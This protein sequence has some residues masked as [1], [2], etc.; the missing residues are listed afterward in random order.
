MDIE[1]SF[2]RWLR[3]RRRALDL[4][5][6]DL[7]RWVGCSV[8]TIRKI[9][10]DERRPSRQIA[11]R[12]ANCLKIPAEERAAII[13]LARGERYLDPTSVEVPERPLHAPPR[14][15]T[16][17]PAPLTHL[18]GRKQDNAAVR[19]ALLRGETRLLTLL[20]PPGIGKTR[21]SITVARDI[22]DAFADGAYFVVLAP[23][24][25]PA[26][27]LATI[28]Q[29]LGVKETAGQ[30]LLETLKSALHTRRLLLLLDNFEHLLEAAPLVVELLEAC[31]GLK[32][33]VTSRATLHV[34]GER[35]YALPPLLLPDLMQRPASVLLA[36]NPAVALFVE[37]AQAVM[38]DF[39]LT[40]QNAAAVAGICVR[41]EGLPLAIELA[42]TRVKLL[43]PE[44][45][46]ARLE[47]RLSLLT[48]GPRDL[49][50]RQQTL[51]NTLAWSYNLLEAAEQALFRRLSVFV[52]G[53]TLQA[54][55]AVCHADGELALDVLSGM[56]ALVDKSL[57]RQE[58]GADGAARFVMLETIREYALEQLAT[59]EELEVFRQRHA[60][61][62]VTLAEA[63]VRHQCLEI[64]YP[65]LRAALEWS[66]TEADG[67]TG[68]RLVVALTGFWMKNGYLS[69][70]RLW[71]ADALTPRA[72]EPAWPGTTAS[73][74]LRAK[75]LVRLG[76][77]AS[78][79]NDQAA[80]Q[81]ALEES[82]ALFRELGETW[83]IADT[84]TTL[85]MVVLLRGD[86]ERSRAFLEES[87]SLFRQ[88]EDRGGIA[89][90]FFF[91]GHL[92]YAQGDLRQA[93]ERHQEGLSLF[94]QLE[95]TWMIANFLLHLGI[96]ALD[97]GDDGQAGAYLTE[98]LTRLRDLG[99]R[100][101]AVHALEECAGLVAARG[102]GR[103]D[104]AGEGRRAARLFGAVEAE[105][106]TLGA[107]TLS[108]NQAHY[109]RGVAAARAL[110][111][112]AT[113]AAA[114]AAG[115][116]MTLEQAIAYALSES[117]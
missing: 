23:L 106:E 30:P 20:G 19:N 57:L 6:D 59:S 33:L 24:G 76:T 114:W 3:A 29:T 5:Q 54:A 80:A 87:L 69:E 77:V 34:R 85:G 92:A 14:P 38:P 71:L 18:I 42:A 117:N 32:A 64:E 68:L 107:P 13:T 28:A 26:L 37:R 51:R 12:L 62:F 99:D 10:A 111:D 112:G 27:V 46:L 45:L 109:Q 115:R 105:R 78:W 79:Q 43:H 90:C 15:P 100:W 8:V 21:L 113:F 75:A 97:E 81:P 25:D 63:G 104:A 17:L 11:E 74:L 56:A 53:C 49:P 108:I 36:R 35:L 65:N 93:S 52:G 47:Q 58:A 95:D 82:L 110:L 73:C 4:T 98:S 84:L 1:T 22:Q 41:L 83:S 89:M 67:T 91:M 50:V 16:N 86:Y 88:L 94:R 103:A 39:R 9:E 70:G 48:G 7:A 55:E 101:L 61:F 2:G 72:D 31:P 66:R 40:E 96:V 102:A 60:A 116:A 44:T